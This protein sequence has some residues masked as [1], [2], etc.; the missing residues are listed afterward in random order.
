MSTIKQTY[1][2]KAPLSKVW[3]A[4]TTA[5]GGEAW[6]AGP[7]KFDLHEGGEFSYWGGDINGLNTKVIEDALLAQD[8]Y[9]H[10]DPS[11]KFNVLFEF[12]GKDGIT[13]VNLTYSGNIADEKKDIK[14]WQDYYFTPIKNLLES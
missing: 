7:V 9:G 3:W 11:E 14:D 10:D 1:T 12:R 4:L 13:T 2:V 8:W 6:D 5:E